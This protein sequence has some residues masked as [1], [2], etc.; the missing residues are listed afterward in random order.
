MSDEEA[1]EQF[2]GER[3]GK[4]E[5]FVSYMIHLSQKDKSELLNVVQYITLSIVPIILIIKIMKMYLPIYDEYKGNI[6]ILIEVIL[7][8]VI[9][10][11]LFWFTHR[12]IMFIPTYSKDIYGS[13]NVFNFI[14]PFLFILFTLDTT[15]SKKVNLLLNRALAYLGLEREMLTERNIGEEDN[16]YTPPS[17][18]VPPPGP[19]NNPY[20]QNTKEET[21]DKYNSSFENSNKNVAGDKRRQSNNA[22]GDNSMGGFG[23]HQGDNGLIAANEVLG[24]SMY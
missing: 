4:I 3:E 9:L 5:S 10:L 19:M 2:G 18:Q 21:G 15:V 22:G 6:E 17:I 20:P 8:L 13:M 12:I 7:Q 14:I 23:Q 16:I 1:F 11:F 24:V